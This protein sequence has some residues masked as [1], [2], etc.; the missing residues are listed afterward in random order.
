LFADT[1]CRKTSAVS[2]RA[3]IRKRFLA[4]QMAGVHEMILRLS[5]GY[6][7]QVGEGGCHSLPGGLS[8][9]ASVLARAVFGNPSLIVLDEPSSNL[10]ADGRRKPLTDCIMQLKKTGHPRS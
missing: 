3:R 9:A 5:D 7:T 8:P 10:D 4:S 1:I 6:D 2:R